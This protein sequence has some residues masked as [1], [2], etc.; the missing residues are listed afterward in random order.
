MLKKSGKRILRGQ[1]WKYFSLGYLSD[2]RFFYAR[3]YKCA[4]LTGLKVFRL[5]D[6]LMGLNELF[7]SL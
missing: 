2:T 5:W 1:L 4:C 6:R 7:M 3:V